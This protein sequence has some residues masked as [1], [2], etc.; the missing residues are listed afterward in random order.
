MQLFESF[1][2]YK[3]PACCALLLL[4]QSWLVFAVLIQTVNI[5]A[6]Q[7]QTVSGPK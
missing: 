2:S 1:D 3:T 5:Q 6:G 7:V 4:F